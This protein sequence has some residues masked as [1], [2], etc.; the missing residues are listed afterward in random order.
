M[1]LAGFSRFPNETFLK[2]QEKS[3]YEAQRTRVITSSDNYEYFR[4]NTFLYE[5]SSLIYRGD[6]SL[7]IMEQGQPCSEQMTHARRL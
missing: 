5:D 4:K 2:M 6:L 3:Y 7:P 1:S